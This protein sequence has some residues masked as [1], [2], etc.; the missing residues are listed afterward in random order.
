VPF[1]ARKRLEPRSPRD[2]TIASPWLDPGDRS[3]LTLD[4]VVGAR[5][6]QRLVGDHLHPVGRAGSARA[7]SR[8]RLG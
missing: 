7:G 4:D 2:G 5:R 6:L 8:S 1:R 3:N